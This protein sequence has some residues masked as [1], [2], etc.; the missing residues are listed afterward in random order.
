MQL[1]VSL[2]TS[3]RLDLDLEAGQ[4]QDKRSWSAEQMVTRNSDVP[5]M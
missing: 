2:S 4:L 1:L 3:K 5:Q